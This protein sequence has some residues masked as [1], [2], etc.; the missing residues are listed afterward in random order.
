[1]SSNRLILMQSR[2]WCLWLMLSS[3]SAGFNV[4]V[5][6]LTDSSPCKH[7]PLVWL[8]DPMQYIS[9]G[10]FNPISFVLFWPKLSSY[11]TFLNQFFHCQYC[12]LSFL[13]KCSV[14]QE[15]QIKS[16]HT[17]PGPYRT[18]VCFL[19]ILYQ[20]ETVRTSAPPSHL[21]SWEKR[22]SGSR[23]T[24]HFK[25]ASGVTPQN[26][27]PTHSISCEM[28]PKKVWQSF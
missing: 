7:P 21:L 20:Q 26:S 13:G 12:L 23:G 17:P 27:H 18:E 4:F 19:H 14:S 1:M 2:W 8:I 6:C 15:E 28:T 24:F 25:M 11:S 5:L 9:Q 16:K 10:V 22:V 3:T